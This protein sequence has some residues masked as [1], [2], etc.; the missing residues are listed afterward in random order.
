MSQESSRLV[1]VLPRVRI[2]SAKQEHKMLAVGRAQV[3]PDEDETWQNAVRKP[4]PQWLDI[5]R[6]NPPYIGTTEPPIARGSLV[7]SDDDNWLNTN[8][9]NLV[10][11]LYVLGQPWDNWKTP[12][13]AFQYGGFRATDNVQDHITF[14]S[15][16][17]LH[18]EHESSLKLF[19]P[20][21]LRS[22][23]RDF[24]IDIADESFEV[25]LR[26]LG[27]SAG[28]KVVNAELARRFGANPRDRIVVACYHLF[29]SQFANEFTS[30]FPQDY[31][32]YCASLEAAFNIDGTQRDV[33]ANIMRRLV[34]MYPDLAGL[35]TWMKGL[36][37][38]RSFFVHGASHKA[39]KKYEKSV[40]EFQKRANN[41]DF[42]RRL[43]LDVTH[44]VLRESLGRPNS[45]EVRVQEEGYVYL[46]KIFC[47]D[48]YWTAISR[49][50]KQKRCVDMILA[51]SEE[52]EQNL[53]NACRNFVRYHDWRFMVGRPATHSV[54]KV[55]A[56]VAYTVCKAS[57]SSEEDRKYAAEVGVAAKRED[58]VA[59]RDWL[60]K[61]YRWI[62]A[63]EGDEFVNRIKQVVA[64]VASFSEQSIQ[65]FWNK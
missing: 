38:E 12:A 32:A 17:T 48:D 56:A 39:A 52:E 4:R 45:E 5:F 33:G 31:A 10:P 63:D 29:R 21:E 40:A 20:L 57:S 30:P 65:D 41:H 13:E 27:V 6:E 9:H 2:R 51:Y 36:Y 37:A 49:H 26:N 22:G 24:L 58:D 23:P 28:T 47:S 14:A 25:F 7:I 50:F 8:M 43:C 1:Y 54:W 55:L 60:R 34:S 35:E 11:I 42:L 16:Y 53:L 44:E 18:I 15:K 46:H 61:H 19:P 59:V 3:W 62:R 64:Q